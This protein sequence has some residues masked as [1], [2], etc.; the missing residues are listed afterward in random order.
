LESADVALTKSQVVEQIEAAR[1]LLG[2][3]DP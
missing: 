2:V 1:Y 3:E